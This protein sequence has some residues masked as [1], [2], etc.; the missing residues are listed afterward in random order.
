MGCAICS[1]SYRFY[2]EFRDSVPLQEQAEPS[3]LCVGLFIAHIQ[4]QARGC[5]ADP[6]LHATCREHRGEPAL[7]DPELVPGCTR[8]SRA[9]AIQ[10]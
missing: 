7:S 9:G 10:L 8:L 1:S 2:P 4:D 5:G 3:L 6:V